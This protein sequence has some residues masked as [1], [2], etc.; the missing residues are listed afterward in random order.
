MNRPKFSLYY[1]LNRDV[2]EKDLNKKQYTEFIEKI[3]QMTV[4]QHKSIL[5]LLF[6]HALVCG[7]INYDSEEL[8]I[9]YN[10]ESTN[11]GIQFNL[12]NFP[13]SLKWIVFKFLGI[14]KK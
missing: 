13:I 9:P 1:T 7:D 11:N 14:V 4:N 3:S 12:D 10:C 5:L 6:E 2:P 8:S